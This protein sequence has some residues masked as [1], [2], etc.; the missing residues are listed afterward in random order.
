MKTLLLCMLLLGAPLAQ[1]ADR[2]TE[3]NIGAM[4]AQLIAA[5]QDKNVEG[6]LEHMSDEVRIRIQAPS[7]M[8]GDMEMDKRQYRELLTQGWDGVDDYRLEVEIQ[9]IDITAD[10]QSASVR[11]LTRETLRI[12]GSEV[13]ASTLETATLQL[14]DGKV[15]FSRIDGIIQP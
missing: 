11:D 10:G 3:E 9:Q 14:L 1:A 8:G 6:V 13:E 15:K 2:L 5:A 7:A 4:Y 12:Q